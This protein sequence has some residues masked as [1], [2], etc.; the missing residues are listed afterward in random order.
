M[1]FTPSVNQ[2]LCHLALGSN[3]GDR[4][5]AVNTA[6]DAIGALNGVMV[7]A[8]S[9]IIETDAVTLDGADPQRDYRNAVITIETA[10]DPRT[11]LSALQGIELD[12]GRDRRDGERWAPRTI[13]I[14][15]LLMG[16]RIIDEPGLTV[17]HPRMHERRF[18]LWP[19]CQIA[20]GAM[21]PS[22]G[23]DAAAMLA[24][25]DRPASGRSNANIAILLSALLCVGSAAPPTKAQD[26][27]DP[28]PPAQTD[29]HPAMPDADEIYQRVAAA[30]KDGPIA[31]RIHISAKS[32]IRERAETVM[33]RAD[34]D[35]GTLLLE[36]GPILALVREDELIITHADRPDRY[37]YFSGHDRTLNELIADSLPPMM[38][39]HL[40]LVFDDPEEAPRIAPFTGAIEWTNAI[41]NAAESKMVL[42]GRSGG[43]D[44]ESSAL[45]SYIVDTESWRLV[46]GAITVPATRLRVEMRIEPIDPGDPADWDLDTQGRIPVATLAQLQPGGV[47]IHPGLHVPAMSL[48]TIDSVPWSLENDHEGP[49][50]IMLFN[51]ATP[52]LLAARDALRAAIEANS[53]ELPI[54]PMLIAEDLVGID[55]F[56]R[57]GETVHAWGDPVLW[58]VSPIATIDRFTTAPACIVLIDG[59]GIVR[60]IIHLGLGGS[61][62]D[63]AVYINEAI[64]AFADP[65]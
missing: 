56:E 60:E 16:E 9:S 54:Q 34:A 42:L 43:G 31:E 35:S 51:E 49:V 65:G 24:N 8:R 63:E 3:V 17:P 26:N 62:A 23:I 47:D 45:C 21:H 4:T 1:R 58:S 12:L 64:E 37:A 50:A 13:D 6:I 25:L 61:A 39:P 2:A 27:A 19:L 32:A 53:A 20:P 18:V 41:P 5:A 29:Q 59:E 55:L 14:D 10:L 52:V 57:L 15:I 48:F 11:L 36:L 46:A 44:G 22:L 28:A 40:A 33:V 7:V 38:F 30:Y